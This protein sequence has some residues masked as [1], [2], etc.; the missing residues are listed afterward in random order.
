MSYSNVPYT[1]DE[2]RARE[3]QERRTEEAAFQTGVAWGV[4][5]HHQAILVKHQKLVAAMFGLDG[6]HAHR[7]SMSVMPVDGGRYKPCLIVDLKGKFAAE[8]PEDEKPHFCARPD[9]SYTEAAGRAARATGMALLAAAR[10]DV[11]KLAA[12][13]VAV[14]V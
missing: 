6:C 12:I 1:E 2:I 14:Y 11:R 5:G 9:M 10:S 7:I 4:I 13:P 8:P 3:A